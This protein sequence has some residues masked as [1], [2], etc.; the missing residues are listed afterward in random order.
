M[1]GLAGDQGRRDAVIEET[2]TRRTINTIK[3]GK[4][5]GGNGFVNWYCASEMDAARKSGVPHCCRS[6]F[7]YLGFRDVPASIHNGYPQTIRPEF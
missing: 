1:T 6:G 4:G 3:I 7:A 5:D 2:N